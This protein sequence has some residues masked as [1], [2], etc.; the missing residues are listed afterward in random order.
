MFNLTETKMLQRK[1][2]QLMSVTEWPEEE[3]SSRSWEDFDHSQTLLLGYSGSTCIIYEKET[4]RP[5]I[6]QSCEKHI[7]KQRLLLAE[8]A[9]DNDLFIS[10]HFIFVHQNNLYV[11]SKVSG[12]CLADVIDCTIPLT[13][14]HASSV[15]KKVKLY[16]T[17]L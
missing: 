5:Y 8:M 17:M 13:E 9:R 6:F 7:T 15:L 10:T 1:R 3:F 2:P 14:V 16:Y 11:G 4:F 12:I